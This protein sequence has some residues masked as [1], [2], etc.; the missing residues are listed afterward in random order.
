[1]TR[2]IT[3]AATTLALAGCGLSEPSATG[4]IEGR[5]T[6]CTT[7]AS[8][9]EPVCE[10]ATTNVKIT[11]E[12][13][14][15][16]E[17]ATLDSGI[18]RFTDVEVGSYTLY[19]AETLDHPACLFVFEPKTVTVTEDQTANVAIDGRGRCWYPIRPQSVDSATPS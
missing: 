16:A 2:R 15:P 10:S 4:H 1:M 19:A 13:A 18:F 17:I 6:V 7:A 11:L 12:G 8:L 9:V 3:L 14:G 5:I